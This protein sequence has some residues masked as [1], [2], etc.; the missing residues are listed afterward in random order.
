MQGIKT[1]AKITVSK[2]INV[3]KNVLWELISKPGNLNNCHPFCSSNEVIQWDNEVHIDRLVYLNGRTYIRKF[4]S[5]QEGLGYTLYIGEEGGYQ[6]FVEWSLQE[7][8]QQTSQL[9]ITVHP[10]LLAGFPRFVSFLPYNL[11]IRP[12]LKNYLK[13]V[14]SGFEYVARTGEDVPRNHFGKHSWFS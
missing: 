11:W 4:A 1:N 7:T 5:W 10:Y 2:T 13:S 12:K 3:P 14:V 9:S 8:D 6:S